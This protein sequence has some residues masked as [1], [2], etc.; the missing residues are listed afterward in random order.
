[1]KVKITVLKKELY[2]DYA[3]E[4][5]TE[6]AAAG[7]CPELDVGN[8]FFYEGGAVMPEGFCPYA[9]IDLY[10]S[11]CS[12]MGGRELTNTWYKN[13]KIKLLCCTDGVRPVLF[14]LEQI[15]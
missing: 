10:P 6:G 13:P 11:I 9:W 3:D 2:S 5:L 14:K 12:L 7:A 15:D 8:T 1:M 4:F